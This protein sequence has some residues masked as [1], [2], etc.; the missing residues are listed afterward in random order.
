MSENKSKSCLVQ[1]L[2]WL[3]FFPIM[4]L[5]VIWKNKN[6]K[7]EV[8]AII[9]AVLIVVVVLF[10]VLGTNDEN[11]TSQIEESSSVSSSVSSENTTETSYEESSHEESSSLSSNDSFTFELKAG[12]KGEYGQKVTFNKDTELE[13]TYFV[14]YIPL[15][16]YTVTNIGQYMGQVNIYSTETVITDEGWEEPAEVFGAYLLDVGESATITIE[17]GQYIEIHE[18]D[19]FKFEQ[20]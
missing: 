10:G 1:G 7:T 18:P 20:Q 5:I 6:M 19:N 13:E 17:E 14:Y 4:L 11:T 12:E 3:F 15:G 9:T 16:T 8:K 2:L